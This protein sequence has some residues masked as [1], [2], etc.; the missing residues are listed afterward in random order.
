M[1]YHNALTTS[2]TIAKDIIKL[3]KNPQIFEEIPKLQTEF[4]KLD[5]NKRKD[6]FFDTYSDLSFS[7]CPDDCTSSYGYVTRING[8]PI[9]WRSKKE[10]QIYLSNCKAEYHTMTETT[11]FFFFF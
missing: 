3:L 7:D 8:K 6:L 10:P 11:I 9:S 1:S 4:S 2:T 5:N